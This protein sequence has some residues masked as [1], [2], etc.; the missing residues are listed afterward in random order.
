M[1]RFNAALA[2]TACACLSS[3]ALADGPVQMQVSTR[4]LQ[5]NSAAGLAEL[6]R[7]VHLAARAACEDGS[8]GVDAE[9]AMRAC[10]TDLERVGAARIAELAAQRNVM[11]ATADTTR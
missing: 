6:G 10:R 4:G 7:R 5:L 9:I 11:V 2:A 8:R 1:N 3:A